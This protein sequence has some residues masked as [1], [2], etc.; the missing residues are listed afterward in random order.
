MYGEVPPETERSMFPVLSPKQSILVVAR[1]PAI[2]VGSFKVRELEFYKETVSHNVS[3]LILD[4]FFDI[5][6]VLNDNILYMWLLKD[7]L[8][9]R[10]IKYINIIDYFFSK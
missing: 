7:F 3:K 1:P 6:F 10:N 8:E 5:G 4:S 9:K 2:G